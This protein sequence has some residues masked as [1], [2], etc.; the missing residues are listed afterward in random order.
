MATIATPAVIPPGSSGSGPEPQGLVTAAPPVGLRVIFARFWPDTKPFRVQWGLT[1][2]LVAVAPALSAA[3]IWLFKILIDQV[4]VPHD[5]HLF[6][7]LAGAYL[8][9]AVVQG[10]VSFADEYLSTWVGEKFVL[11]LRTRLFDHLHQLSPGFFERRQLGDILSRLTGDIGAIEELV[12]SGIA[13]ALTYGFQLAWYAGALFYLNWH[14]AAASLVAAPAFL[15]AARFFSRRIKEASR[16]KRRRAGSITTVAEES[17]SNAALVR[18]YHHR[19]GENARFAAENQG[20]FVAQMA[21]TRLQAVF[22]PLTDLLEVVGVLLV[23]GLAVWEL[24]NGRISIGGLLAFVAYLTQLY[25]PIQGAGRLVN[26]LY[27]ASASA[28]RVI[29]LLDE[30]PSVR[31]PDQPIP[32]PR[33]RGAVR[34]HGVGF[35]YPEVDQ[36]ALSGLTFTITAGEKIAIVGASGAGKSTLAKLLLRFDDPTTGTVTIDGVDLRE[37]TPSDLYRNVAAVLQETLVFDGTIRDN[38]LWGRPDATDDAIIAAATAADAHDFI[39]ALPQGYHTRVG[40]RGRM[41][42]G[43]QRQR[44][45]IARAMI[46]DA[47]ILLLDEP[48]TGLDAESTR[49]VLAPLRRLMAGRTTLIISHNL[50]TVTDADRILFLEHG[51]ITAQGR[52]TELLV[53]SPGYAQLYRLHQTGNDVPARDVPTRDVPTR[54]VPTREVLASTGTSHHIPRPHPVVP[55]R[56]GDRPDSGWLVAEQVQLQRPG[57]HHLAVPEVSFTLEP[58][59]CLAVLGGDRCGKSTLLRLLAGLEQPTHGTI[60]LGTRRLDGG[61]VAEPRVA[62]VPTRPVLFE[63]TIENNIRAERPLASPADVIEAASA[64]GAHEL[65]EATPEAYATWVDPAGEPL[66]AALVIRIAIARALLGNPDLLLL[67][68]PTSGLDRGA[69]TELLAVLCTITL[70]TITPGTITPGTITPGRITVLATRDPLVAA[71]ADQRLSLDR[72]ASRSPATWAIAG[73]PDERALRIE[74]TTLPRLAT[75]SRPPRRT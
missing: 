67:D 11:S 8:A 68:E 10:V 16:E 62:L 75:L 26:S 61:P 9:L 37:L 29:E 7:V 69:R 44:L 2:A 58:N 30:V 63:G 35:S 14:L 60:H 36:A 31:S 15:A 53:S 74:R 34:F 13:T 50:L 5:F 17:L 66:A 64:A 38:I 49:R 20:S 71:L 32:L 57:R 19:D 33:A 54:D 21:A 56:R 28:E 24:T 1:L 59:G 40:Q 41:L 27:S 48:T 4:V 45:A 6:P 12:L 3:A 23:I 52:H 39:Q 22:G 42:S 43:G 51:Q 72:T 55:P 70:G 46:R 65:I 25:G 73:L 18:A 47:P